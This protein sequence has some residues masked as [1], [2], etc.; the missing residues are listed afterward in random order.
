M[1]SAHQSE[2][3]RIGGCGAEIGENLEIAAIDDH[4]TPP[5]R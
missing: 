2:G 3:H 5:S 1:G 4:I